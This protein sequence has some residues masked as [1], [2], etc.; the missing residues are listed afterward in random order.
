MIQKWT[1]T[2]RWYFSE[3]FM[4]RNAIPTSA[5]SIVTPRTQSNPMRAVIWSKHIPFPLFKRTPN[6][7]RIINF[8]NFARHKGQGMYHGR[9]EIP[10]LSRCKKFDSNLL[11]MLVSWLE[12]EWEIPQDVIDPWYSVNGPSFANFG[13]VKTVHVLLNYP[14]EF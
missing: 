6:P 11:V 7:L 13:G 8:T 12:S 10:I 14:S 3:L 1:F 4:T 9:P 2:K 5:F